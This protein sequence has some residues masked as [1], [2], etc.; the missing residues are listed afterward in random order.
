M[1]KKNKQKVEKPKRVGYD[2]VDN[3]G[4]KHTHKNPYHP[5]EDK[6]KKRLEG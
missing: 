5:E 1:F 3:K 4:K 6:L 2:V